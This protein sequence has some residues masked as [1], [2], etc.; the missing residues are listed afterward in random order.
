MTPYEVAIASCDQAWAAYEKEPT[1]K[2]HEQ[3]RARFKEKCAA[4]WLERNNEV[5]PATA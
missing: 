4:F 1:T 3:Y 2:N 5:S